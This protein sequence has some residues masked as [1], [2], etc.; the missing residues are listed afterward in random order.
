MEK[1]QSGNFKRQTA[2]GAGAGH[3]FF[4][5]RKMTNVSSFLSLKFEVR[6]LKLGWV[7]L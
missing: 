5:K 7:T 1:L 3:L 4:M 6:S 2:E